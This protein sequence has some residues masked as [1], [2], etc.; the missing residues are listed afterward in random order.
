MYQLPFGR[1][2]KFG[3]NVN[4]LTDAFLGGWQIN[5]IYR[6]DDGLPIQLGLC[7]G[8]SVNLPTYGNQYPDLLAPLEVAG[9]GNLNQYFSNPQVAIRPAPVHRWQRPAYLAQCTRARHG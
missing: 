8:C 7:G 6:V 5:G 4:Q 9:A 2:R 3:R 1:G